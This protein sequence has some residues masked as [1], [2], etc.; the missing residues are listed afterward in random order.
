M[1]Y[2]KDMRTTEKD[3]QRQEGGRSCSRVGSG[4]GVGSRVKFCMDP[5]EEL[6]EEETAGTGGGEREPHR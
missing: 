4:S 5:R 6:I 1:A 2:E 3:R